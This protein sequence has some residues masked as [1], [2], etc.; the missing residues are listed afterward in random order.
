MLTLFKKKEKHIKPRILFYLGSLAGG[1][2]ERALL[3]LCNN[4]DSNQFE[5]YLH[6]GDRNGDYQSDVNDKIVY[7]SSRTRFSL[8]KLSWWLY[9]VPNWLSRHR[10]I[11]LAKIFKFVSRH[12]SSIWIENALEKQGAKHI[13]RDSLVFRILAKNAGTGVFWGIHNAV[14][15][16][17]P[18]ILVSTMVE[19]GA[20]FA[21]LAKSSL[22]HWKG[23]WMAIEQNNTYLRLFDYFPDSELRNAWHEITKICYQQADRTVAVSHGVK[24]GLVKFF[25]ISPKKLSVIY[26]PVALEKIY[27][28][29]PIRLDNPFILAVGRL[30]VQK[31]FDHVIRAFAK[32]KSKEDLYLVILGKG[33]LEESL[34]K[35]VGDLRILDRVKFIGFAS[36]PWSYMKGAECIVL[37]SRYEGMPLVLIEAMAAGCP[38]IAYDINYGPRE[39]IR[40][41]ESG[42]LVEPGNIDSL[43]NAIESTLSNPKK[44]LVMSQKAVESIQSFSSRQYAGYYA[45]LMMEMLA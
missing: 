38:A 35:L 45:L 12:W 36:N 30:H 40:D 19:S 18:D 5:V 37:S 25:G 8:W 14:D 10:L 27:P 13:S 31:Q 3:E 34:R 7:K 17:E 15:V 16:L 11:I 44:R 21:W 33:E 28:S 24:E 32:L 20:I 23:K 43:V 26:N 22:P 2:A 29:E 39:V 4:I 1:G 9:L 42:I 41:G 6:L